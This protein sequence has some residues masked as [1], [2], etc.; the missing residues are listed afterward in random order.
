V[1]PGILLALMYSSVIGGG[2]AVDREG[3]HP[4]SMAWLRVRF[5]DE[6][7]QL[8]YR[9]QTLTIMDIPGLG[10]DLD[11]DRTLSAAEA[12][13]I[14]PELRDRLEGAL[15]LDMDGTAWAPA[16]ENF[17]MDGGGNHLL[18]RARRAL[19][20]IPE[21]L[22]VTSHH[23][24]D[25]G[26]PSHRLHITV[27]G[28]GAGELFY[29]LDRDLLTASFPPPPGDAGA[30][31]HYADRPWAALMDY[32]RLGFDHVLEGLDHLAFL[33]ALLFGVAGLRALVVAVTAFTLAHSV[34]LAVSALGLFS[35]PPDFVEPVIAAS[36]VVVLWMHLAK[37]AAESRA[38]LPAFAFG[39]FH[40]FG[41]AGALGA[42]GLPAG[43]RGPAL[44][45][46]NLGVEAGQLS[47]LLP[48]ALV[49]AFT[50]SKV[51]AARTEAARLQAGAVVGAVALHLVGGVMQGTLPGVGLLATAWQ[52]VP[53]SILAAGLVA[54]ALR[55]RGGPQTGALLRAL[56]TSLLLAVLFDAGRAL[57]AGN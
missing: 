32:G 13:G 18:L 28:M 43:M 22:R 2:E 49:A 8:E 25:E 35:L 39:L 9:V 6:A 36:V 38:W 52:P 44:V 40:G 20:G 41:F 10:A 12:E 42:I 3:G 5:A 15:V 27:E 54:L 51:A 16:F 53:G 56:G 17:E 30:G 11:G 7:V 4:L 1:V 14:W 47:F 34:T 45:G 55:A 50:V 26:N 33:L 19:A 24:Y 48:V 23:F 21:S 31:L 37:G 29:L 46:F 57:G